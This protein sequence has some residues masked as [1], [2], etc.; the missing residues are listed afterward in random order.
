MVAL[1]IS[2]NEMFVENWSFSGYKSDFKADQKIR[3]AM[4]STG[5]RLGILRSEEIRKRISTYTGQ[6]F[7]F[8][9]LLVVNPATLVQNLPIYPSGV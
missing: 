8:S 5:G 6:I 1:S 4:F 2:S 9:I 7:L 3:K